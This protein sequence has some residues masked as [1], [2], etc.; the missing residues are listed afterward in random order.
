MAPNSTCT[1]TALESSDNLSAV[2]SLAYEADSLRMANSLVDC[3][4]DKLVVGMD[5]QRMQHRIDGD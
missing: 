2:Q 3:L 5:L 1:V 4:V